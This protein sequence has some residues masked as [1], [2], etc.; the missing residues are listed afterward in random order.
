MKT[1]QNPLVSVIV[2]IRNCERTLR[3]CLD[4]LLSQTYTNWE[5][6]CVDDGSIDN[7]KKILEEYAKRDTRFKIFS[8]PVAKGITK[9]LNLGLSHAQGELIARLDG[10]DVALPNRLERQVDFLCSHPEIGILG[11]SVI[12]RNRSGDRL[13]TISIPTTD[14]ELKKNL[15]KR[16]PFFH[17][18]V[19]M[20]KDLI[21][22]GYDERFTSAE[23]LAI[24]IRLSKQTSFANLKEPLV[25]YTIPDRFSLSR[26]LASSKVRFLLG[27][28]FGFYRWLWGAL[29]PLVASLLKV[30]G[31]HTK[32]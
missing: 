11:S 3:E 20:R 1:E 25:I 19:M 21:I 26:A 7:S 32:V 14:V 4:S 6:I 15:W 18:T 31:L 24:W 30:G 17:P 9:P 27:F 10:D 29:R 22:H 28:H 23:D 2:P 5:A 8:N 13:G 12:A 16:T